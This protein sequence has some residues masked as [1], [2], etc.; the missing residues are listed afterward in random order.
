MTGIRH[1]EVEVTVAV[2]VAQRHGR[3]CVAESRHALRG[4]IGVA[5][6]P[7]VDVQSVTERRIPGLS[8]DAPADH[9]QVEVAVA[10]DVEPQHRH[11]LGFLVGGPGTAARRSKPAAAVVLVQH[12]CLPGGAADEH[13]VVTV[14]VG[15]APGQA[16]AELRQLV[17]QQRLSQPRYIKVTITSLTGELVDDG[18]VRATFRQE[19]ES[20]SYAD[21][22]TKL[23]TLAEENGAWRIIDE[24]ATP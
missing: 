18:T 15:I 13:V 9:V 16:G 4:G 7:V 23:L 6:L 12:A 14:A 11:V 10:F 1:E 19:Y 2:H 20:D 24:R 22:V 3:R 21:S 5:A 17:R 8:F